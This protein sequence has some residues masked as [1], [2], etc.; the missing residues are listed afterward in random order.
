MA[1]ANPVPNMNERSLKTRTLAK[2][3]KY[4]GYLANIENPSDAEP[5]NARADDNNLQPKETFGNR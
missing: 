1:P 3:D 4:H 2:N 5:M